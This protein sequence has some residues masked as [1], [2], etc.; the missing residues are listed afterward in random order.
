MFVVLLLFKYI[1]PPFFPDVIKL[2]ASMML[3]IAVYVLESWLTNRAQIKELWLLLWN[4]ESI[5]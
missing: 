3:G 1:L 5:L 2:V 4:K